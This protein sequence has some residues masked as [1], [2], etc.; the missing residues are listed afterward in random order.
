MDRLRVLLN[1]VNG[2]QADLPKASF[3]EL[4]RVRQQNI[5]SV[6]RAYLDA[7]LMRGNVDIA[8]INLYA[9]T[10]APLLLANAADAASA[11]ASPVTAETNANDSKTS[12]PEKV[13]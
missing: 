2:A 5:L 11:A 7:I 9:R 3:S 1:Q 10:L 8:S 6:S 4:Q 12:N 13:S